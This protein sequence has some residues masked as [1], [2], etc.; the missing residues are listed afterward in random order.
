M[1]LACDGPRTAALVNFLF[2]L[3]PTDQVGPL[4]AR[5][6]MSRSTSGQ[7]DLTRDGESLYAGEDEAELVELLMGDAC[8]RLIYYCRD[9]M[10]FHAAA[11]ARGEKGIL[12]PGGIGSGKSTLTAWLVGHGFNYLSDELVFLPHGSN[13]LHAFPRPLHLKRPSRQ[14][15]QS[16]I[17]L[18]KSPAGVMSSSYSDLVP[19][20]ALNPGNVFSQP[21]VALILFPHFCQNAGFEWNALSCALGGLRLMECLVNA[22][23]LPEQGF[24]EA[25]RL[26]VSA[27]A[28]S[29]S[30]SQFGKIEEKITGLL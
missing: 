1:E 20:D 10:V 26:A 6:K 30:Y 24:R 7:L 19:P 23:N 28:F 8:T 3:V 22:R 17:D 21:P 14:V 5:Y 16:L 29:A 2:R 18:E 11:L 15:L 12:I 25:A 9:G 4:R 13:I 27:P